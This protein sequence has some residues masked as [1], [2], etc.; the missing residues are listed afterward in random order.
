MAGQNC[1]RT[2]GDA[3]WASPCQSTQEI[4]I[5][6][7]DA[8]GATVQR[9]LKTVVQLRRCFGLQDLAK[10]IVHRH[11]GA[12]ERHA[13]EVGRPLHGAPLRSLGEVQRPT[14][15][16]GSDRDN[17]DRA[18]G[19]AHLDGFGVRTH[20]RIAGIDPPIDQRVRS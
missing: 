19:A 13:D 9:H 5:V 18:S 11:V 3:F 16:A 4:A 14:L 1:D 2:Y 6:L 20:G 7:R 15:L 17:Q 10:L 8:A 12:V